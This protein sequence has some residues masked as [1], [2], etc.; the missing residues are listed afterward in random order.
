M[1]WVAGQNVRGGGTTAPWRIVSFAER[2]IQIQFL[3]SPVSRRTGLHVCLRP[4]KTTASWNWQPASRTIGGFKK[5]AK[6][7]PCH[8]G[9]R[10]RHWNREFWG[11]GVAEMV[12]GTSL[13]HAILKWDPNY[14]PPRV[15]TGK[16]PHRRSHS[17]FNQIMGAVVF[18]KSN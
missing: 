12:Q 4:E 13:S 14:T 16:P 10:K 5:E 3:A 18:L 9:S 6:M 15:T 11:E 17:A 8:G 7:R 1:V 2:V